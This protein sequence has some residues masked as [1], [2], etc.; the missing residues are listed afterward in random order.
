[1]TASILAGFSGVFLALL[2]SYVPKFG[3]WFNAQNSA[4]KVMINGLLLVAVAGGVYGAACAGLA[5]QL[6]LALTCDAPGLVT[7]LGALFSALLGNQAAYVAFVK[8][9]ARNNP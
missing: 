4:T 9:F 3:P 2:L 6:N 7:L 5:A 1:M 8:P